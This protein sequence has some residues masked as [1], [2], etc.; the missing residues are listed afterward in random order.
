MSQFK[1]ALSLRKKKKTLITVF[2]V[3]VNSDNGLKWPFLLSV[4]VIP[5]LR[6]VYTQKSVWSNHS[7]K[8]RHV[9]W[10]QP[11]AMSKAQSWGAVATKV[12]GIP[13]RGFTGNAEVRSREMQRLVKMSLPEPAGG[14]V[15]SGTCVRLAAAAAVNWHQRVLTQ[16]CFKFPCLLVSEAV[17]A[18]GYGLPEKGAVPPHSN[19]C[20]SR[21]HLRAGQGIIIISLLCHPAAA[22]KPEPL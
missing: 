11:W 12:E 22:R 15:F 3:C 2:F 8:K 1:T 5:L 17:A 10:L 6:P 4:T 21:W 7:S 16:P 19:E 9:A 14:G 18:A 20:A 13:L